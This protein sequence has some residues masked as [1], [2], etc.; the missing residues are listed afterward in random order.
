[1]FF[2]AASPGYTD[3]YYKE[4]T[5]TIVEGGAKLQKVYGP[6]H[7][8]YY[9]YLRKPASKYIGFLSSFLDYTAFYFLTIVKSFLF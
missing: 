6:L 1:M 2:I 3:W 4:V 9:A 8:L 5:F 7:N